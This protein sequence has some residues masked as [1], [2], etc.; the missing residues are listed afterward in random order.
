MK[1]KP[2]IGSACS[3]TYCCGLSSIDSLFDLNLVTDLHF[4]LF[5]LMLSFIDRL[6]NRMES[7]MQRNRME[8]KEAKRS[9]LLWMLIPQTVQFSLMVTRLTKSGVRIMKEPR[10]P[11]S[12][13]LGQCENPNFVSGD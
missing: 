9:L 6:P 5:L 7:R 10:Q 8:K 12:N 3:L 4:W 1:V 2:Q 11:K 13:W